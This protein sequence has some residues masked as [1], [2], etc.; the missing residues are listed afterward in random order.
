[1][2]GI[3]AKQSVTIEAGE[4]V[5]G[6]AGRA[7]TLHILHGRVWLTVEG[8][9]HDYWLSAG[10]RFPTIPGRLIVIEADQAGSQVNVMNG[11]NPSILTKIREHVRRLVEQ[12]RFREQK[13]GL[14]Q[15]ALAQCQQPH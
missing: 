10:A 12:L 11:C 1:M 2:R 13:A 9:S 3:F 5:S 14:P 7:Q 15:C 8:V 6:V 4:A